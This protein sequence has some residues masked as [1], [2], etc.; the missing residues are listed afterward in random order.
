MTAFTLSVTATDDVGLTALK[1]VDPGGLT[2]IDQQIRPAQ[3][4]R[5]QCHARPTG[6]SVTVE[7]FR[8]P[9]SF[10]KTLPSPV[11]RF[12]AAARDTSGT[13]LR[14]RSNTGPRLCGTAS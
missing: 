13:K 4:A 9:M 1:V 10:R 12:T 8:R 2:V 7:E 14:R 6:Q 11:I 5:A 3:S